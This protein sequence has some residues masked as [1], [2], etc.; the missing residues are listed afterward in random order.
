MIVGILVVAIIGLASLFLFDVTKDYSASIISKCPFYGECIDDGLIELS[1]TK[2]R[3]TVLTTFSGITD[4]LKQ[5]GLLCHEVGHPLGRFMYD[6]TGDLHEALSLIDRTCGGSLYHG[7]MQGYFATNSFS[8]NG[9]PTD[10]VARNACNELHDIFYS[11]IRT[12]CAHGVGHGLIIAH[13]YDAFN[14]F[15]GCKVFEEEYNQLK[16]IGGVAMANSGIYF[17]HEDATID[18]DDLLFPCT[19]LDERSAI[20]CLRWHLLYAIREL[21]SAQAVFEECEKNENE[22]LVKYCYYGVGTIKSARYSE[23]L[24]GAVEMCLKGNPDYQN[25]CFAGSAYS[26]ADQINLERGFE[27]CKISPEIFLFDCYNTLGKW[28]HTIYFTEEEIENACSPLRET[29]YYQ[30]CINA[31]PEELGLV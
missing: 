17:S 13:N 25:Y 29:E 9:I 7:V 22:T 6:Y 31:N 19:S 2:D 26:V 28:I 16:C 1:K 18:E 24:E 11:D 12:T 5:S 15:E 3:E 30:V 21:G 14:A 10:V 4:R 20:A 8:D 23:F 27:F